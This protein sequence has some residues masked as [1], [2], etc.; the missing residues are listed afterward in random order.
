MAVV[1]D[2][3]TLGDGPEDLVDGETVDNLAP[4][5]DAAAIPGRV[6]PSR[7]TWLSVTTA[8]ARRT[9]TRDYA[10]RPPCR[11]QVPNRHAVLRVLPFPLARADGCE[12][13]LALSHA[14][15]PLRGMPDRRCTNHPCT[16]TVKSRVRCTACYNYFRKHG[17]ERPHSLIERVLTTTIPPKLSSA[18][19]IAWF[20]GFY[21]GEGSIFLS[22]RG[23]RAYPIHHRTGASRSCGCQSHLEDVRKPKSC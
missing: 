8:P 17:R 15:S 22:R 7:S 1:V 19:D 9:V 21:E 11:S 2:E 4:A 5:W 6:A 14:R 3:L 16:R 10:A 20:A 12:H 23:A 18:T 13:P